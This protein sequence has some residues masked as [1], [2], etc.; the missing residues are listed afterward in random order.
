M[1][2]LLTTVILISVTFALGV[3]DTVTRQTKVPSYYEVEKRDDM[4]QAS[5]VPHHLRH[6]QREHLSREKPPRYR[7]ENYVE[8]PRKALGNKKSG[9]RE[10]RPRG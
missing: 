8:A 9:F 7:L 4:T 3:R 1:E 2:E 6:V 5:L 10:E